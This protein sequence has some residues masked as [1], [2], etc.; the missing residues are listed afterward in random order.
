MRSIE[1]ALK[2]LEKRA[3][4]CKEIAPGDYC[5]K[6]LPPPVLLFEKDGEQTQQKQTPE[7]PTVCHICGKP[8]SPDVPRMVIVF[9]DTPNPEPPR[10]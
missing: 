7:P 10:R 2:A 5:R 6:H 3:R 4:K 9:E 1:T 8:Y